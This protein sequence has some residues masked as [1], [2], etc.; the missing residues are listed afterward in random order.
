M[1]A[2]TSEDP[3]IQ[4]HLLPMSTDAACLTRIGRIDFDQLSASFFRFA[5]ELTKERRPRGICNAFRQTMIVNHPVHVQVFHADH[6]ETVYDLPGLL[7]GEVLPPELDAFMHTRD[8]LTVLPTLR[9]TLSKLRMLALDFSKGFLF[10]AEKA[11]IINFF[12]VAESSERLESY[13]DTH[14]SGSRFK[15]KRFALTREGN[16]PFAGRRPLHG[17]GFHL[18]FDLAMIDHLHAPNLGEAHPLIMRGRPVDGDNAEATLREGEAIVSPLALEARIARIL[19]MFSHATEERL[20]SQVNP[21]GDILKYLRVNPTQGR[22]FLFQN[23]EGRVLL[24]TGE[25]NTV[26][27]IGRFAHLQ[28]VIIE[29]TALFKGVVELLFLLLRGKDAVRKH[30]QHSG[31]VV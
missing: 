29:P 26:P 19:G 25:G 1:T 30:F 16:V 12:F 6:P 28:Q 7:M 5:R 18:A 2:G 3:H 11:G 23:R 31:I 24:K 14:L 8:N 4:G 13:I 22:A 9:G 27:F 15:T 20:K 10:L 17:T 21:D